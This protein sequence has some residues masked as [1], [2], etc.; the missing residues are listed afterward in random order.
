MPKVM[1]PP[2]IIEPLDPRR[3]LSGVTLITHGQGG[4]AGGEVAAT[5]DRIAQRAGGAAQYVMTV[6]ANGLA[7]AAVASFVKDADSPD[8]KDVPTGEMI[9]KLDYGDVNALPTG[10][11]AD[12]VADYML[13]NGLAEQQVHLAGPSRGGSLVSNLAA[14]LGERGVWVDHVTYIDPVPA[15]SVVPI[16]GIPVDGPMRVTDNIIFADNYWRSDDNVLTGFDG[17]H[18]DGAHEGNLNATVQADNDGD[19]HVG[20]GAYYIATIN[21]AEPLVPPARGSWFKGTPDAPDRDETG[22]VFSRIAGATRPADGLHPAFGGTAHRDDVS[23]T[24]AQ[25]ANVA[26]VT[27]IGGSRS[28]ARGT[29]AHVALHYADA[30]SRATVSVFLDRDRNPYNGNTV[31]RFARRSLAATEH[32]AMRLSG[33]TYEAS[34]G[35]Y[36]V[37]A[38]ITDG[39]GHVRYAYAPQALTITPPANDMLFVTGSGGTMTVVGTVGN[40]R[41]FAYRSGNNLIATLHEFTQSVSLS[42]IDRIVFDVGRGDD[43]VS[44]GGGVAGSL[45]LGSYGNDTLSGGDGNDTLIGGVGNDRLFGGNANDWLE[46]A[47]GND[48][49]DGGNGS[50]RLF[51][52]NGHDALSGGPG[53]DGLFGGVGADTVNGGAGVD[54]AEHADEDPLINVP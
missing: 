43:A 28:V 7:G 18:V 19:P 22:Y 45:I 16:P 44:L 12:A 53:N 32:S 20:A 10:I 5:A 24:G 11:A 27:L 25:W 47:G 41:I 46:G 35:T 1:R 9:I 14:S 52:D 6:V 29:T 36:H 33:P 40:D 54:Q 17:Q 34:P 49:L 3:L 15:E 50:D 37:Y 13:A 2:P 38:H 48:A 21:P 23:R 51:G 42:G 8:I 4:S 31:T 26:G 30:D 39:D